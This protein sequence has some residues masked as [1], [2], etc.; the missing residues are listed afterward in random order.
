MGQPRSAAR[1]TTSA[2]LDRQ[3][4]LARVWQCRSMNARAIPVCPGLDLLDE[5]LLEE[6]EVLERQAV[7]SATQLSEFSATWHG[8]PV[9]WVSSLSTLRSRAPPPDITMPLS[10]MSELSSGGVCSSTEPDRR[11]ELL[12]RRLDGLHDLG[13]GDRDGPRQAGDQV[14]AAHLH[15]QFALE[16][17]GGADLDLDLLGRALADHEVVLLADVRRDRLVELVATDAQRVRDHDAAEGDDRT[18][19]PRHRCR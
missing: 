18:D 2:G 3:S 19:A 16:R 13:A 9:T 10:M 11:D 14:A 5:G 1:R 4:K 12:Q 7:P 15:R 6:V 17:Q 8:T